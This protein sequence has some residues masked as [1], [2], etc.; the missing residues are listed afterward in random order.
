MKILTI[1]LLVIVVLVIIGII[2]LSGLGAFASLT[3]IERNE[4]GFKVAG[5]LFTG[6]YSKVGPVMKE[7]DVKLKE[8]G[9]KATRGFGIY[10]D[11]PATTSAEKCRSFVGSI[12]EPFDE[13]KIT[14]LQGKGFKTDSVPLAKSVVVEFPAKSMLSYMIGPMKAYP[15]LSKYMKEKNYAPALSLEIYDMPNKKIYYVMQ[16]K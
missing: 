1:S 15:A 16:Y 5:R 4:G 6:H 3:V 2:W 7:T 9:I 13:N 11:D 14:D 8:A 10:Y 12:L